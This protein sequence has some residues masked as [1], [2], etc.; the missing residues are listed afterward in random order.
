MLEAILKNNQYRSYVS[1]STDISSYIGILKDGAN[2]I[3]V[4]IITILKMV[5]EIDR[6]LEENNAKYKAIF[7]TDKYTVY[8]I[9]NYAAAK[10]LRNSIGAD[11]CIGASKEH[12]YNYGEKRKRTTYYVI[13]KDK[14][15]IVVHVDLDDVDNNLITSYDNNNEGTIDRGDFVVTRGK[16]VISLDLN[17]RLS[18][19]EIK[20]LFSVF[21][22]KLSDGSSDLTVGINSLTGIIRRYRHKFEDSITF[23]RINNYL[24]EILADDMGIINVL[25]ISTRRVLLICNAFIA[26]YEEFPSRQ[27]AEFMEEFLGAVM[28]IAV[29]AHPKMFEDLNYMR[30]VLNPDNPDMIENFERELRD[31]VYF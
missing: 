12:F 3:L 20:E 26:E 27:F 15:G 17:D 10:K 29:R 31:S 21:G 4:T 7:K 14:H 13:F 6:G 16:N 9:E 11:W 1:S 19:E 25:H 28:E 22:L 8:R 18:N 23:E 5:K 30:E 24:N 2:G